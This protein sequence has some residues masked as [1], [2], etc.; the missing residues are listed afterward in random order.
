MLLFDRFATRSM[1]EF[2]S[3]VLTAAAL[4]FLVLTL[5]YA[6]IEGKK[7]WASVVGYIVVLQM[8]MKAFKTLSKVITEVTRIYPS[9]SRLYEFNKKST[10]LTIKGKNQ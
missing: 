3:Y 8:V 10:A 4:G 5:G 6:A 7:S 9:L 2:L 1:T